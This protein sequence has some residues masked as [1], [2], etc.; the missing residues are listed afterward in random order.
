MTPPS[1]VGFSFRSCRISLA[2]S[3]L[4]HAT[5]MS[6]S[7]QLVETPENVS[8]G[9]TYKQ[10][11]YIDAYDAV[12]DSDYAFVA[13]QEIDSS[14]EWRVRIKGLQTAGAVFEPAAMKSNARS[15]GAQDKPYFQWGYSVDPSPGD[16]RHIAFRVYVME[17][18]PSEVEMF[19]QL[20]KF[21]GS[22]DTPKS[23]RFPWPVA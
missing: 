14:G 7:P 12:L 19:V 3:N 21:D 11:G 17:G 8:G 10:L 13:F 6:Q 18:R 22:P 2:S 9:A 5:A 20:R 15:T 1:Q 16:P 4:S 23:V